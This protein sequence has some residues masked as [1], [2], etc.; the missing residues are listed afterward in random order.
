MFAEFFKRVFTEKISSSTV[1]SSTMP[2]GTKAPYKQVI[3]N[4]N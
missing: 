2:K 1:Q 3:N 4:N